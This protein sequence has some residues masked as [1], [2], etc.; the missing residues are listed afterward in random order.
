M[1]NY[2][3]DPQGLL[4]R[5]LITLFLGFIVGIDRDESWHPSPAQVRSRFTF[6]KPGKHAIGLGGVRTYTILALFGLFLGTLFAAD[7]RTTPFIIIG[8]LGVASY[9]SI[10]YFLNFFDRHTLG[11][12]SEIGL[13]LLLSLTFALGANILDIRV[14]IGI[15]VL[16]SLISNLKVEFKA[17][18]SSFSQREVLESV[19]FVALSAILLPWL[20]NINVTSG[21]ITNALHFPDF[22]LS[23][24]TL[25]NP[26]QLGVVVVFI[27]GLNFAGYFLAKTFQ[28]TSSTLLTSFLGGFISSTS[29]TQ[30]LA[31][32]SKLCKKN[33]ATRV[34]TAGMLIANLSSFIR[35][36]IIVLLLNSSLAFKILPFM[37]LIMAATIILVLVMRPSKNVTDQSMTI[38]K[39]PLSLKPAITFGLLFIVVSAATNY[40]KALLGS[41][42]FTAAALIASLSGLDAVI[43]IIS[44]AAKSIF[45]LQIAA[46]V[47]C[48]AVITNILF[49]L[50]L[51]L[52]YGEKQFK[53]LS[54]FTLGGVSLFGIL[55]ILVL[56]LL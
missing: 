43:L 25:L 47:L 16:V 5:V 42:G 15:A 4:V 26:F 23:H 27:S 54:A 8:F 48:G 13:L 2:I 33:E 36:P 38:F 29:V 10:A 18:V 44:E 34:L 52:I 50:G 35:I 32:K 7:V 31:A 24:I 55:L 53:K 41:T 51:I 39:S 28:S 1:S 14:I 12:T 19:E 11:L 46:A 6:I 22:P 40:G 37:V 9:I 49:K 3:L 20:P 21:M 17:L 45:S 56:Y 30:F